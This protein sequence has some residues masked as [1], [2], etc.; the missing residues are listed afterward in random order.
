MVQS[1]KEI[2]GRAKQLLDAVDKLMQDGHLIVQ[3]LEPEKGHWVIIY[4][5]KQ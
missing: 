3:I 4:N 5:V 2:K 1:K